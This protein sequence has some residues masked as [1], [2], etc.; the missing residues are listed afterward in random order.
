MNHYD[1]EQLPSPKGQYEVEFL[2]SLKYE[3][4]IALSTLDMDRSLESLSE[5]SMALEPL[6]GKA[7]DAAIENLHQQVSQDPIER[8]HLRGREEELLRLKRT[9]EYLLESRD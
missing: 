1:F 2:E 6:E 8:A 4:D 3:L 9:V 5:E 7:L